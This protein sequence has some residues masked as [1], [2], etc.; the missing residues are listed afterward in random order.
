MS[1]RF[2]APALDETLSARSINSALAQYDP[3]HLPVAVFLIP[4]EAEFGLQFYRDQS[5]SRYELGQVPDGEHLVV[6]AQ[7]YPKGVAK[8]AGRKA[9]YLGNFTAQRLDYFYVPAR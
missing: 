4:R 9:I 1:L 8:A 6:A 2:G 7:G 5:I 3:H